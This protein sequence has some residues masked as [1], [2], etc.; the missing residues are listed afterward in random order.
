M[1]SQPPDHRELWGIG[2]LGDAPPAHLPQRSPSFGT[3]GVLSVLRFWGFTHTPNFPRRGPSAL[4]GCPCELFAGSPPRAFCLVAGTWL[5]GG[6]APSDQCPHRPLGSHDRL[7][8][9]R[10]YRERRDS[11]TYRCEERSPSFGEDCYGSSRSHHRRRSREREPYRARKHAHHCHKRRTRSCSSAS[12]VSSARVCWLGLRGLSLS[13]PLSG[14]LVWVSTAS[15]EH[16][17]LLCVRVCVRVCVY[18][19]SGPGP[20]PSRRPGSSFF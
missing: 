13:S 11:D 17:H 14:W 10:R 9:Q 4:A 12:S 19:S 7:P 20:G 15:P 5:V 8:Y 16:V 2:I 3:G 18:V 1:L 6:R